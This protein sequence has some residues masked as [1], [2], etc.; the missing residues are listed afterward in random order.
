MQE[1]LNTLNGSNSLEQT[2]LLRELKNEVVKLVTKTCNYFFKQLT[3]ATLSF[4]YNSLHLIKSEN[5]CYGQ[6]TVAFISASEKKMS[7]RRNGDIG[8][9][10]FND[11]ALVL[12]EIITPRPTRFLVWHFFFVFSELGLQWIKSMSNCLLV[13]Q[14]LRVIVYI[15]AVL[16]HWAIC[17]S[18]LSPPMWLLELPW[19]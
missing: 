17:V 4:C 9:L 3:V 2:I 11:I 13:I 10:L 8:P 18:C 5:V 1:V 19:L 7:E 14:L 6:K 16:S 12:K 15:Q